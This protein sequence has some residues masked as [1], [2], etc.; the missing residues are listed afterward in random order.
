[1]LVFSLSTFYFNVSYLI[2]PSCDLQVYDLGTDGQGM[3]RVATLSQNSIVAAAGNIA[4]Y[5]CNFYFYFIYF[6]KLN[7]H[8]LKLCVFLPA[9]PLIVLSSS[10]SSRSLSSTDQSLQTVTCSLSLMQVGATP[11]LRGS[12]SLSTLINN[13]RVCS[14]PTHTHTHVSVGVRL[15]FSTTPFAPLHQKYVAVR[16]SLLA[17]IHVRLPPGFSASSTLQKPAKVHKALHSKG[18][19]DFSSVCV[20]VNRT[21]L[22]KNIMVFFFFPS[23]RCFTNGCVRVRGQ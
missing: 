23:C 5:V 12:Q 14:P 4:R 13:K 19:L 7:V 8:C 11:Q 15:Y 9:G 20:R 18:P 1:M 16:P 6:F 10:P 3:S 22:D 2:L 17:L 21:C